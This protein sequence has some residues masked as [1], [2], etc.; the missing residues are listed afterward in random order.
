[1]YVCMYVCMYLYGSSHDEWHRFG[2]HEERR[3]E[4]SEKQSQ[5]FHPKRQNVRR[6][7]GKGLSYIHTHAYIHIHSK[8]LRNCQLYIH[9]YVRTIRTYVNVGGGPYPNALLSGWCQCACRFGYTVSGS[10]MYVY[11][12]YN[13]VDFIGCNVCMYVRMCGEEHRAV[14]EQLAE[15]VCWRAFKRR[16]GP[17]VVIC[18]YISFIH[19]YIH[20]YIHAY[21][22]TCMHTYIHTYILMTMYDGTQWIC[23]L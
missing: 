2:V 16:L 19:T 15:S 3:V 14:C 23:L 21:I 5:G 4:M 8:Q 1:M 11:L 18:Y 17:L 12:Q 10:R 6:R 20:T 9:T 22:Y 7:R 13:S